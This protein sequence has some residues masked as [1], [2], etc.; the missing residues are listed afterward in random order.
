VK[1]ELH[2]GLPDLTSDEGEDGW[3]GEGLSQRG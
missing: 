3:C 2:I 1:A